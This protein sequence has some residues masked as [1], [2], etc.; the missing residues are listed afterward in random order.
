MYSID[1]GR[2]IYRKRK[3]WYKHPP[4]V[5]PLL[6]V[7]D[8]DSSGKMK[9]KLVKPLSIPTSRAVLKS[10]MVSLSRSIASLDLKGITQLS[11]ERFPSFKFRV[12]Y[13]ILS[14]SRVTFSRWKLSFSV[15]KAFSRMLDW[16]C[17]AWKKMN[18]RMNSKLT[19]YK[20]SIVLFWWRFP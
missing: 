17:S 14:V 19:K 13:L 7:F 11:F 3:H 2:C 18:S 5:I 10:K 9:I 1:W 4:S 15:A 16:D 6:W 20:W 12:L 8:V